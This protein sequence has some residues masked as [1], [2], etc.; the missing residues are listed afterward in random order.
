M[1]RLILYYSISGHNENLAIQ[2]KKDLNC[3]IE[4]LEDGFSRVFKNNTWL[5]LIFGGM[6]GTFNFLNKGK[7]IISNFNNYD[8]IV[9]VGPVWAFHLFPMGRGFLKRNR[10]RISS[11]I[12]VS[13]CGGGKK[14]RKNIIEDINKYYKKEPDKIVVI[15]DKEFKDKEYLEE[16][17]ELVSFCS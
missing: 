12:V 10:D 14:Y 13:I 5:L 3:D 17:K 7:R 16:Y 2:L 11:L 1:K 9:L 15:S 8:Q 6:Y 4:K